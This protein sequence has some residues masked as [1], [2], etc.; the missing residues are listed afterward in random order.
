MDLTARL[1]SPAPP[2]R[3]Q[4]LGT[5][6]PDPE[7]DGRKH[8]PPACRASPPPENTEYVPV[9]GMDEPMPVIQRGGTGIRQALAGMGTDYRLNV[10]SDRPQWLVDGKWTDTDRYIEAA[11][12]VEIAKRFR[13]AKADGSSM[14][15]WFGDRSWRAE[16]EAILHHRRT[17]PF[18]NW[19][20]ALP[21]WDGQH[22]LDT[23]LGSVFTLPN[24]ADSRHLTTWISRF[25]F[26]GAIART[27]RP[28][29]KLDEMPVLVGG[30]GCGKST[31]VRFLLPEDEDASW[32]SDALN[33]AGSTK[34][35]AE[36]LE[37]VV[38]AEVAEMTGS[39]RAELMSLKAFLS[40]TDDGTG[41]RKAYARNTRSQ[42][43]RCVLIGTAN[44]APLPNDPTGNRRFVALEVA[45]HR[46]GVAHLR[47]WLKAN[48]AQIWA[49]ALAAWIKGA[50]PWLPAALAPHQTRK[51]VDHRHADRLIED[52][53]DTV[54]DG[55]EDG[56][57]SLEI[58]D[59]L[60]SIREDETA[61]ELLRASRGDQMRLAQALRNAGFEC[62]RNRVAGV[63][64]YR[65]YTAVDS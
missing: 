51:N 20:H 33:L 65:W 36:A 60:N 16:Y 17:D 18:L 34:E 22:R 8:L 28:G 19:L 9:P 40:R 11:V 55:M 31:A 47:R 12:R 63:R 26:I 61:P 27:A 4:A 59:A 49:E 13:F 43:R 29:T 30:Q 25:P 58:T 39:T 1:R 21:G 64:A 50:E 38:I 54:L 7:T 10:R 2:A 23:W 62:V 24:D 6:P 32:F 45:A 44:E 42:K 5:T 46:N 37:G 48:R 35:R 41:V 53:L 14:P 56:F 3:P 15:A 57:T 52:A